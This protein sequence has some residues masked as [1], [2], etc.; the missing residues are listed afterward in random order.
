MATNDFDYR[1]RVQSIEGGGG[2]FTRTGLMARDSVVNSASHQVIVAVNAWNTFQVVTRTKT[3]ST[4]TQS[5]PPNPLPAAFGSNS[6]VRL[7][8]AGTIFYTYSSD[9]GLNWVQL[10]QFDSA[11][12][13]DGPFANPI[14]LG[15]ATSA[16]N[17]QKTATTVV[18]DFGITPT[19][20]LS[21]MLSL[22]LMEYRHGDYAKAQELC[23]RCLA[24]SDYQAV[25]VAT[26]HV[27]LAMC[28]YRLDYFEQ[29]R[30]ELALGRD[31]IQTKFATGLDLG[32]A[33]HGFWFDWIS[34][35]VLLREATETIK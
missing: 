34:A 25:R 14:Y 1:L 10:H 7:Q 29:A 30:S 4:F 6:W 15:I 21:T 26:A 19:L 16:W 5:Q 32:N 2:N 17:N 22:A 9:D 12:N 11:A 3:G 8:R 35:R 24:Y 31:M 23:R 27:I 20:R 28:C 13:P 33:A 18:S